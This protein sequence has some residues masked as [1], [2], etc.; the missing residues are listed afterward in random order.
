LVLLLR[1]LLILLGL[2]RLDR[3]ALNQIGGQITPVSILVAVYLHVGTGERFK[4]FRRF[5]CVLLRHDAIVTPSVRV[6]LLLILQIHSTHLVRRI[7]TEHFVT[8]GAAQLIGVETTTVSG[9]F[10]SDQ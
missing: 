10:S 4:N 6:N 7:F 2:Q 1:P 5:G 8:S 3:L 9:V